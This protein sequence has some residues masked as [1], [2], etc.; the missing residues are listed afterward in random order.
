MFLL[1]VAFTQAGSAE[2][3]NFII[4]SHPEASV[5][6]ISNVDGLIQVSESAPESVCAVQLQG[7]VW[8]VN[9]S[10]GRMVFADESGAAEFEFDVPGAQIKSGTR[11]RIEGVGILTRKGAAIRL[12]SKGPIVDNDGV[13]KSTVLSGSVFLDARL[14]PLQLDWFNGVGKPGLD[15]SYQGPGLARQKIPDTDLLRSSSGTSEANS[16]A[17]GVDFKCYEGTWEKIP[18]FSQLTPVTVGNLPNFNLKSSRSRDKNV[19]VHYE[20]K[21]QIH[22]AGLYTFYVKSAAG[23]R[24]F[25][26]ATGFKLIVT[27]NGE[28]PLPHSMDLERELSANTK[29][30]W[31]EL[32]G[33]ITGTTESNACVSLE[34]SEGQKKIPLVLGDASGLLR[35]SLL[36]QRFRV[37][38]YCEGAFTV[39]G[40]M[41]A[42]RLLVPGVG[43]MS[44]IET[45]SNA[46]QSSQSR[47]D[48]EKRLVL[49]TASEVR[50]AR[51]NKSDWGYK[52]KIRGVVTSSQPDRRAFVVQDS[53]SG[54][55]V[56][57][58]GESQSQLPSIGDYVDAE[59]V[60]D[61]EG[62]PTVNKLKHL[63]AG[64]LPAPE[65]PNWAQLLNGSR[66]S[67]YIELEGVVESILDRSDG[68]SRVSL[69]MGQDSIKVELKNSGVTPG[70][71]ERYDNT[72][73]RLRGCMFADYVPGTMQL[74]VGQ[75]RMY[76]ADVFVEQE[77]SSDIESI[78]VRRVNTLTRFDPLFDSN[79]RI[80]VSGQV[81]FVRGADYFMMDGTNGLRFLAKE[82]LG[83]KA[84][85]LV[86]AT[87]FAELSGAAPVLRGASARKIGEA[88]LPPPRNVPVEELNSLVNDSTL[89]KTEGILLGVSRAADNQVLEMQAGPWRFL[90]RLYADSP[91]L[92]SLRTGSRLEL[93]G[94]YCAQGGYSALGPDIV[95]V[96]ILL[97]SA[98][99]VKI[100]AAPPWWTLRRLLVLISA[101][102]CAVLLSALW[103]FQLRRK[104]ELSTRQLEVQIREREH[105]EYESS[106]EQ[107]RARIAQDLHDELGSEITEIGMLA[108]RAKSIA[109][110]EEE[111]GSYLSQMTDKARQMVDS[112]EEIV[113]AMNP[114]HNSLE[115]MIGYF[116]YYAGRFLGLAGIRWHF[117][118]S[119]QEKD[120]TVEFRRRHEL[121]LAFKEALTNIVRHSGAT[122]VR[123]AIQPADS[124]I[125]LVITDN[126]RGLPEGGFSDRMDGITNMKSRV[127]NLGGTFTI[128][129]NPGNGTTVKMSVPTN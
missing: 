83:L 87:G 97:N 108:A 50:Q 90:A 78:P 48:Q 68:W 61:K 30:R 75:I 62:V 17:Y 93:A 105:L 52:F 28:L 67:E 118:N 99:A 43:A 58:T 37:V 31:V 64:K 22:Q 109:G 27:G 116:S 65:H 95:P 128:S 101:L 57:D 23:S 92:R 20:T 119:T 71:I 38:G 15:V 82:P 129:S 49:T 74:K 18:D 2:N 72:A 7:T 36:D 79:R 113:W 98:S 29:E 104:V 19:G 32:E 120:F 127:E 88:P 107:E 121:F 55:F 96:D 3:T 12:G 47:E 46:T 73:I 35:T 24:L 6:S 77:T 89:I 59:G 16:V 5:I 4:E 25:V 26:E 11:A 123:L 40:K 70:P 13:H 34:L 9:T 21:L 102:A 80:K 126:G 60:S 124:G 33:R 44:A 100:L 84:G 106:M 117:E 63:G 10:L 111:R 45:L 94:V 112:L 54:L 51:A 103:I 81:V 8:W 76:D 91:V 110:S 122:E 125:N 56:A 66:D 114:T 69:R 42:N 53:T 85:D 86:E 1:A 14:H 115:S 39:D 41:E